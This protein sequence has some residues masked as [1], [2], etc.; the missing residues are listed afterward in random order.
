ML[1]GSHDALVPCVKEHG[2]PEDEGGRGRWDMRALMLHALSA[3]LRRRN[4][5]RA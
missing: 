2:E 4:E 1:K 3:V 5:M